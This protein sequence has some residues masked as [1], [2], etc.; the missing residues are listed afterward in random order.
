L[1]II[2]EEK[3][4]APAKSTLKTFLNISAKKVTTVYYVASMGK[5]NRVKRE[6]LPL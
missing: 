3:N 6:R 2:R 4:P 5:A 1:A